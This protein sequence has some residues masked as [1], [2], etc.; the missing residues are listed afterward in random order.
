MITSE[1]KLREEKVVV[2]REMKKSPGS[3]PVLRPMCF[4][5]EEQL[6]AVGREKDHP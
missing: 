1:V 5:I 6:V 3:H 4:S 2:Q